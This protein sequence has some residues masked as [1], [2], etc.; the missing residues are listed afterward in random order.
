MSTPKTLAPCLA[1]RTAV[2]LPL[3]Q[4]SPSEPAPVTNATLPVMSS[5]CLSLSVGKQAGFARLD[6]Q[7]QKMRVNTGVRETAADNPEALLRR[8][9]EHVGEFSV[10]RDAPDL[11]NLPSDLRAEKIL[12]IF[13]RRL[14]AGRGDQET[15]GND[16]P[17][18]QAHAAGDKA[19]DVVILNEAD[20]AIGD[21]L[22]AA[23]IEIISAVASAE[24][25]LMAGLILAEVKFEAAPAQPFEQ[26][27]VDLLHP[28]NGE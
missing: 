13:A 6:L 26:V 16:A 11:P 4:P 7:G 14:I 17:I 9:A 10:G 8:R 15:S 19:V 3:P 25:H 2:A 1:S 27:L 18:V 5:I 12:Q 21:Q 28:L 23:A 20:V 24:L 22:R